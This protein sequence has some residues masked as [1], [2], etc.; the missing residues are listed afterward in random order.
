MKL[1]KR[2]RQQ[3]ILDTFRLTPSV[4]LGELAHHY[5]VTK[6]TIRR[7]IDDLTG[8]GLL[9]RTYGGA[10]A[11]FMNYEPELRER[12]RVNPEGRRRMAQKVV[13]LISDCTIV[14]IDTGATT[15]HVCDRLVA[16]V[17]KTGEVTLTAITNSLRNAT[18]LG[19]NPS[20]RVILCPGNYDDRENAAFGP[21]TVEFIGRYFVDAVV[22]SAGGISGANVTDANS[23]A[24]AVKRAMLPQGKRRV[25]VI[26]KAKFNLPQFE[27][28]C[29]VDEV[30]DI[31]TDEPLAGDVKSALKATKVHVAS[32]TSPA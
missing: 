10:V 24:A 16:T 9:A 29:G 18:V 25:L 30:T 3:Q 14:M 5:K 23:E 15:A 6:E 2:D 20:I 31:V 1:R 13:D 27:K 22:M 17:P 28:V 32:G 19:T 21:Q 12:T 4:R 26:E 7:D 8:Q 11:S